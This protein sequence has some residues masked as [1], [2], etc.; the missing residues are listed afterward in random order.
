MINHPLKEAEVK[1][2]VLIYTKPDI[3]SDLDEA[4]AQAVTAEYWALRD[5]PHCIDGAHLQPAEMTT[6]VRDA[7]GRP[8]ITDGPFAATKEV[9]TGY[10]VL[11]AP[12]LDEALE[13][14]RRI[15]AVRMGGVVEVRPFAV[16]PESV[17]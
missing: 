12:D 11:D 8:L 10:Y 2:T 6:T 14:A 1:Y 3:G 5:D 4:A 13:F 17:N 7:G 15:P 16:V 9:L